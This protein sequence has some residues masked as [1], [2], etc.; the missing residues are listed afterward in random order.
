MFKKP[1]FIICLFFA[2]CSFFGKADAFAAKP[3]AIYQLQIFQLSNKDQETRLDAYLKN[4]YLPA[5]HRFGIKSVGVF[6]TVEKDSAANLLYVFVPFKNLN[7]LSKLSQV[8]EKDVD[9]L[10]NGKDFINAAYNNAPYLRMQSIILDAFAGMPNFAV[11]NLTSPKSERIYELR[12]YESATA[13]IGL[14]KIDMFNKYEIGIFSK[15]DF[16]AVFYGQVI[17][18]PKM[19]DLIYLTTYNN[20]ADHEAKWKAFG[21]AY[22]KVNK[23]PQY[24]NNVSHITSTFLRPTEYSDL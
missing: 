17:S 19:P 20:M 7:E 6:K 18:G 22:N 15:L 13:K 11:P 8:L 1:T 10:N 12:N 2:L 23:L 3:S 14:N 24:Q 4:A 21:A 9:Y 5:L 16:N